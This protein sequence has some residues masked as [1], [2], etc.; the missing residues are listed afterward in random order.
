MS[1]WL[2]ITKKLPRPQ[3][4]ATGYHDL[5]PANGSARSSHRFEVDAWASR[6]ELG[7]E[8]LCSRRHAHH[9]GTCSSCQRAQLARWRAQLA[10]VAGG[11]KD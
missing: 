8:E 3:R 9:V 10:Q 5:S 6:A 1:P 11:G 2:L 7:I 4:S